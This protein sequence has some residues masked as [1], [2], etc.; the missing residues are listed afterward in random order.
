[1]SNIL[2]AADMDVGQHAFP[3]PEAPNRPSEATAAKT[4][5]RRA[6]LAVRRACSHP[7]VVRA[8]EKPVVTG[9][10]TGSRSLKI[11]ARVGPGVLAAAAQHFRIPEDQVSEVINAALAVV[12][13]PD[14]F[15]EWLRGD[16]DPL[17]DNSEPAT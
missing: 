17:P 2:G 16:R 8:M 14:R 4:A 9:Q 11:S 7:D 5:K 12:A 1:M 3:A 10:A 6:K 13:K 15:K